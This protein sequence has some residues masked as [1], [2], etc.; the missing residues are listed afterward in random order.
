[1][2]ELKI[3][4]GRTP[5]ERMRE[6]GAPYE[7][8]LRT[9]AAMS[10]NCE[11]FEK[12]AEVIGR[13]FM[14]YVTSFSVNKLMKWAKED[15]KIAECLEFNRKQCLGEL[16]Y[17]GME[18]AK[19][20][21]DMARDNFIPQ[22]I[23]RLDD[24]SISKRNTD[25]NIERQSGADFSKQTQNTFNRIFAEASRF[26]GLSEIEEDEEPELEGDGDDVEG[27]GLEN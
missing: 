3:K 14:G 22:F 17:L 26:G 24:G 23:D 21:V 9:I 19:K 25:K 1:M 15:P 4:R 2:G 18:K 13:K 16:V 12:M 27:G 6:D 20:S 11:S 8:L 5:L 7:S 10:F